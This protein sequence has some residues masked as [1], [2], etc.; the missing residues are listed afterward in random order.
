[1]SMR[2]SISTKPAYQKAVIIVIISS[3]F[4]QIYDA[5]IERDLIGSLPLII[6]LCF[7]FQLKFRM[8]TLVKNIGF[9]ISIRNIFNC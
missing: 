4:K 2:F 1:M 3:W 8:V 9:S 6:K 7:D 5:D